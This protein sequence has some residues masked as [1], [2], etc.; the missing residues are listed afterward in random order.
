MMGMGGGGG[1][2]GQ[3]NLYAAIAKAAVKGGTTYLKL[4]AQ[5][6][7]LEQQAEFADANATLADIQARDA[8]DSGRNAVAD[9]Q[10]NVSAFKSSQVNALAE[11]GIDVT[12][13][14]AIDLLASTE[15]VAQGD[16]DTLKYNA[17]MQS[18]GHRVEQT[19]FL[20]QKNVLITQAKSIRP[21][22]NAELSAMNEF[23]STMFGGG[24]GGSPMQGGESMTAM[25]S[26]GG[27]YSSNSNFA[28]SLYSG[29]QGASWQN[30]NWNWM[31]NQ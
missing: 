30:Y 2:G 11:N 1:G 9:Y 31:G 8:I 25:P 10:R 26:S 17:A 14:S 13:G 27:S 21:R 20:N 6:Q 18:W 23:A 4:K 24:G 22:L 28:M 7:A 16:I 19:N 5:K 12:E 3:G 15:M 29:N